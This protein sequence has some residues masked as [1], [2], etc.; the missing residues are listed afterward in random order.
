MT[1]LKTSSAK[2]KDEGAGA[3]PLKRPQTIDN[4]SLVKALREGAFEVFKSGDAIG[5]LKYAQE[6]EPDPKFCEGGWEV[7]DTGRDAF[8]P[9]TEVVYNRLAQTI[10]TGHFNGVRIGLEQWLDIVRFYRSHFIPARI[11]R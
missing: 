5:L 2:S 1:V 8:G 9:L 10:T 7:V 6:L 11:P 3:Y 4:E